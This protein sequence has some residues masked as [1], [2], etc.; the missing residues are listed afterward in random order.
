[1]TTGFQA[2]GEAGMLD[3]ESAVPLHAQLRD[4][5]REQILRQQL[6]AH[7]QLPSERDLCEQYAVSRITVRQALAEL[8][9]EGLIYT[10]IGKGT[11]VAMPRLKEELQPL[12]SFTQDMA[13][14]GMVASSRVL[15]AAIVGA[16]EILAAR[17]Q[18]PPGA[19]VVKLRRLRLTDSLPIAL[20]LTWLPHH[21]CPRLLDYDL[22]SRSLFDILRTEYRLRLVRAETDIEA[23]LAGPEESRLL[24]L[25]TPAAVLI[26]EQTTFLDN[27][28]VIECARSVFCG[29]RY[30]L[31][32]RM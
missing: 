31:H 32:T 3:K 20:Q 5:L 26:S 7:A 19:E 27:D 13:R 25:P 16:D 15:E 29:D 30:Q 14:R 11:Y 18:V 6:T 23:A 17:L 2:A 4:L 22:S 24:Q 21:L 8:L 28:A 1:M 10:S 9:R 12:S